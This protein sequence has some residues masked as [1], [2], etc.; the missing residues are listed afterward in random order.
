M[1]D[2]TIF[3]SIYTAVLA[4]FA[5]MEFGSFCLGVYLNKKDLQRRQ[6]FEAEWAERVASG[7]VPPGMNPMQ[8]MMGGIG[9]M[10]MPYPMPTASGKEATAPIPSGQYL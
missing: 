5:T 6:A 8:M 3:F 4:A 10:P 2:S 9:G 1:F 7:E